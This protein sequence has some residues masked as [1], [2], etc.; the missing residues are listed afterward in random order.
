MKHASFLDFAVWREAEQVNWEE[1][2]EFGGSLFLLLLEGKYK[3]ILV[4]VINMNYL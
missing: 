2:G 3:V 1:K 4:L